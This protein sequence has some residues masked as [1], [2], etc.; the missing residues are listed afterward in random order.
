M[1]PWRRKLHALL[2]LVGEASAFWRLP[3]QGGP[4]VVQRAGALSRLVPLYTI[5][6]ELMH[7]PQIR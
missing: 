7:D 1:R 6:V 3:C 2:L 4:L 5:R